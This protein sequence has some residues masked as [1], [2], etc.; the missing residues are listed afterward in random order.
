[1]ISDD[2]ENKEMEPEPELELEPTTMADTPTVIRPRKRQKIQHDDGDDCP[3]PPPPPSPPPPQK[4]TPKQ[5]SKQ[6]GSLRQWWYASRPRLTSFLLSPPPPHIPSHPTPSFH[7]YDRFIPTRSSVNVKSQDYLITKSAEEFVKSADLSKSQHNELIR[8]AL[9]HDPN[10]TSVL[11]FT[12]ISV[13]ASKTTS[14]I[15]HE[16]KDPRHESEL[17]LNYRET[18]RRRHLRKPRDPP[19]SF[20][21][22]DAP[23]TTDDWHYNVLDWSSHDL[24]AVGLANEVY[25]Y[26]VANQKILRLTDVLSGSGDNGLISAVKWTQSGGGCAVATEDGHLSLVDRTDEKAA[27]S[28]RCQYDDDAVYSMSWNGPILSC[29]FRSGKLSHY[30]MRET[31]DRSHI[32]TSSGHAHYACGLQWS[33]D[34][35][36]LASGGVDD[37]CMIWDKRSLNSPLW[38]LRHQAAVKAIAWCPLSATGTRL[39][40]T[41]AGLAD[42]QLRVW[43]V[44]TRTFKTVE[45]NARGSVSGVHWSPDAKEL[46]T[47]SGTWGPSGL[48][49]WDSHSLGCL[50]SSFTHTN[51]ILHSA[52]SPDGTT[53]CTHSAGSHTEDE[54]IQFCRVWGDPS[55]ATTNTKKT[56]T[57]PSYSLS[58]FIVR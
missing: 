3:Q 22:I 4:P 38:E 1:M 16:S 31:G 25:F 49:I 54:R 27:Y 9:F 36:Q 57:I 45:T 42:R 41:G 33:P 53:I 14:L 55:T 26:Y 34:G 46:A 12:P 39:L 7:S 8:G 35:L 37:I 29:G 28:F 6:Y 47:A 51:R 19:S 20:H 18:R 15:P 52:L 44:N 2:Y 11:S 40:A 43:D 58:R 48:S 32:A 23:G 56:I 13:A 10:P 21:A 50:S 5:I 24:L 17:R 30:D